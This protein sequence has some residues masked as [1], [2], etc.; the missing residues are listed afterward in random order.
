MRLVLV[1]HCLLHALD[2]LA[3]VLISHCERLEQVFILIG[4][5]YQF[6]LLLANCV[7]AVVWAVQRLIPSLLSREFVL[8]LRVDLKLVR[9]ED[10]ETSLIVKLV[11]IRLVQL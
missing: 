2:L 8:Y 11:A 1:S 9:L 6:F 5:V 4:H 10:F 3:L 7:K